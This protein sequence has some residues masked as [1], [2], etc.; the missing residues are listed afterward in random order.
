MYGLALDFVGH[1]NVLRVQNKDGTWRTEAF[2]DWTEKTS[3]IT[4]TIDVGYV[5]L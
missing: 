1:A 2:V 3:S 5:G 4:Y